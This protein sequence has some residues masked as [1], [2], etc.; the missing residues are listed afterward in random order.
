M[1]SIYTRVDKMKKIFIT[2]LLVLIPLN[3]QAINNQK[4]FSE[5]QLC[6]YYKENQVFTDYIIEGE[7]PKEYPFKSNDQI[8]KEYESDTKPQDKLNRIIKEEIYNNYKKLKKINRIITRF[9]GEPLIYQL[10]IYEKD[11]K[12]EYTFSK[13]NPK[14]YDSIKD[15]NFTYFERILLSSLDLELPHEVNP[16]DITIKLYISKENNF[17]MFTYL[18]PQEMNEKYE[19]ENLLHENYYIKNT[20]NISFEQIDENMEIVTIKISESD[21]KTYRYDEETITTKDEIDNNLYHKLSTTIKY[22]YQDTLFK[23]YKIEKEYQD[24]YHNDLEGYIKDE[25]NCISLYS[26][27]KNNILK[28]TPLKKEIQNSM[29]IN[30]SKTKTSNKKISDTNNNNLLLKVEAKPKKENNLSY[31]ESKQKTKTNKI[32]YIIPVI[33]LSIIFLLG[34]L[35][36]NLLK[37]R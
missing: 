13:N 23:Y 27:K 9:K 4:T 17:E 20:T 35:L 6:K 26:E 15:N 1:R 36:Y 12:L 24:G 14:K 30:Q 22:K 32:Y 11:Q 31:K 33:I 3:A 18:Y 25:T 34:Y 37:E 21:I 19:E 2:I 7:N 16:F 5:K 8:I 10:E 28:K 29:K